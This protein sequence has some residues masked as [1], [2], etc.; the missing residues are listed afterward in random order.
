MTN[1]KNH[2][3]TNCEKIEKQATNWKSLDSLSTPANIDFKVTEDSSANTL[4]ETIDRFKKTGEFFAVGQ[5]QVDETSSQVYSDRV[6]AIK[7]RLD[8]VLNELNIDCESLT[9]ANGDFTG[10]FDEATEKA[11]VAFQRSQGLKADGLA[12]VKTLTVLNKKHGSI[13]S[14]AKLEKQ[15]KVEALKE[16]KDK[17]EGWVA[18]KKKFVE[19]LGTLPNLQD[20]TQAQDSLKK[21]K[22]KMASNFKAAEDHSAKAENIIKLKHPTAN[23]LKELTSHVTNISDI[24]HAMKDSLIKTYNNYSIAKS[25]ELSVDPNLALLT[26]KVVNSKLHDT[27]SLLKNAALVLNRVIDYMT[28]LD[29]DNHVYQS[30]PKLK[31]DISSIRA[32]VSEAKT[33]LNNAVKTYKEKFAVIVDKGQKFASTAI[34]EVSRSSSIAG[35]IRNFSESDINS[36][37]IRNIFGDSH[38]LTGSIS[39]NDAVAYI[40]GAAS[41]NN[42]SILS[43]ENRQTMPGDLLIINTRGATTTSNSK[44]GIVTQHRGKLS[45]ATFS[46]HRARPSY[47]PLSKINIKDYEVYRKNSS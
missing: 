23:D 25:S 11:V 35:I 34:S 44:L 12:G 20:S 36:K 21:T 5:K 13:T 40:K 41:T 22:P 38:E 27:N 45:V 24:N 46:R 37:I 1:I 30:V 39:T 15:K 32:K 14:A 26:D 6:K 2:S 16:L 47:Q 31:S 43:L 28:K 17:Y 10:E 33:D 29:S 42:S 3:N 9:D 4:Q 19:Q 7:K 18:D 8:L